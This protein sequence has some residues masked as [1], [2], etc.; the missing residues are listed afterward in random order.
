MSPG[1]FRKARTMSWLSILAVAVLTAI[2]GAVLSGIVANLSVDWYRVSSFEGNSGFLV[3]FWILAGLVGGLLLGGV[4]A[5]LVARGAD[6]GFAKAIVISLLIVLA[7]ASVAAGCLRALADIPPTLEGEELM[8]L[9]EVRWPAAQKTSPA[10]DPELR[11]LELDILSGKV[12][13]LSRQGPLWMEDARNEQGHWI[14]PGAVELF[15]NRGDRVIQVQPAIPGANGLLLPMDGT[16]AA[17]NLQ[18]SDWLPRINANGAPVD[19][20]FSYRFKVIPR[21]QPSRSETIGPFQ[22]DTIADSFFLDAPGS[23]PAVMTAHAEFAIHYRGQPVGFAAA[24][25]IGTQTDAEI[26]KQNQASPPQTEA[27]VQAVATLPGLPTALLVRVE[28]SGQAPTCRM[29][30]DGGSRA[31]VT[32]VAHCGE[33]MTATPLTTDEAWRTAARIFKPIAGRVDRETFMRPGTYLFGDALFDT[34]QR[35][36]RPI[37]RTA[38]SNG[39]NSPI[40]TPPLSPSPDGRSIV[41]VGEVWEP[42]RMPA[43][44]DFDV[45]NN[46][47]HVLVIDQAATRFAG[48]DAVDIEWL[49][50][51][52]QWQ[53]GADGHDRL[54][55]RTNIKPLP[56]KGVLHTEDSGALVYHLQPAG[57]AMCDRLAEFLVSDFGATQAIKAEYGESYSAT[58]EGI[59]VTMFAN[60]DQHQVALF[61][62]SGS[63]MSLVRR[64]A[65]AFNALL[66]T[67]KYDDLFEP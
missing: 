13:R 36:V 27:R 38:L 45:E 64:I 39:F 8:L 6:P 18:W 5:S 52:Y 4:T 60:P 35:I 1:I 7:I 53:R 57:T 15:T 47:S 48:S 34:D 49:E 14:V 59:Q 40:S 65:Q 50:H 28:M 29:L 24:G 46:T 12:Q 55:A 30:T 67:G 16:P 23:R 51:Y 56:Y 25:D 43:L 41:R 26:G 10:N 21:S 19:E 31:I 33:L 9:V 66:A 44:Q 63:D 20:G 17:S 62:E 42:E 54:V 37:D 22:I 11:T 58:V 3:I 2:F 32:V 61:I